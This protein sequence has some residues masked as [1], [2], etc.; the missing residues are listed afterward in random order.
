MA[1]NAR[2]SLSTSVFVINRGNGILS[3]GD[4]VFCGGGGSTSNSIR[5][6]NSGHSNTN[7]NSSRRIAIGLASLTP[8]IGGLIFTIA[9]RSSSTHGRG[10][11]RISG[12]CVHIMGGTSNGRLT[13]FSLDRSTSARATVV[14]NRLC[15]DNRRFGFGTVNRNFTNNL[16]PLT[17]TRNIDVNWPSQITGDPTFRQNFFLF[18]SPIQASQKSDFRW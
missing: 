17:R 4:F 12:N 11:N 7:R 6:V 16:G 1:S 3:S 9:V 18:I 13:H 15:H 8:L 2:F 10:F 14:F 5:R